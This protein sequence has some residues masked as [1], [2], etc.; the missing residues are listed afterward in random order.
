MPA[1]LIRF[2]PR[3][4]PGQAD[5]LYYGGRNDSTRD[6]ER[7]SHRHRWETLTGKHALR[8]DTVGPVGLE[9]TTYGLK[10][11]SSTN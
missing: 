7:V 11:H 3:K 8:H 5:P 1:R 4:P 2:D 9:P 10:V 6:A